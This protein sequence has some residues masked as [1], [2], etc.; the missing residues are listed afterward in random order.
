[1]VKV[2]SEEKSAAM[3]LFAFANTGPCIVFRNMRE[4]AIGGIT[5]HLS[6]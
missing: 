3:S 5:E 6:V 2:F 1:L 4:L